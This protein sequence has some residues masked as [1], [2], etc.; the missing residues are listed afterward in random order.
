[1]LPKTT[2]NGEYSVSVLKILCQNISRKCH[3]LAIN[4]TFHHNNAHPSVSTIMQEYF[5]RCK[6]KIKPHLRYSSKSRTM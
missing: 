1:M 5:S 6:I 3:D 2:V 4:W